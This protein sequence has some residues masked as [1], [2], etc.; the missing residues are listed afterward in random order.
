MQWYYIN[1]VAIVVT[2][3]TGQAASVTVLFI[4][5]KIINETASWDEMGKFY[6]YNDNIY[7][8]TSTDIGPEEKMS[9]DD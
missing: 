9:K 6:G 7:D 8:S 2:S 3:P 5:C 4:I 1:K